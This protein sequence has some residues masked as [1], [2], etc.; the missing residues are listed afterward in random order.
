MSL[1]NCFSSTN[2]YAACIALTLT[3]SAYADDDKKKPDLPLEGKTETL[4]FTTDQGSWLS[5]DVMADGESIVF[6]LLGDLY[7]LPMVG[8][9]AIRI[10][11]GLGFDSQ[12]TVS[13]DGQWLAF[14]SDRS[15]A[16]NV[17]ISKSD[18]SEA[19]K[20]SDEKQ[21]GLISP[22]WTADSQFVVVT[23]TAVQT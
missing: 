6:D 22:A 1:S 19:R 7:T 13:P 16:D 21:V 3:C 8:G 23:K 20:L 2:A 14:I 12:P 10:T 9:E 17:W 5:I 4:S 18:G 15:G 11:S